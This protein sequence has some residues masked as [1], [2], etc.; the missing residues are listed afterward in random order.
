MANTKLRNEPKRAKRTQNEPKQLPT[1]QNEP[2]GALKWPKTTQKKQKRGKRRTKMSQN[3]GLYQIT[4][5]P[6]TS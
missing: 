4:Q 3:Y 1:T 2:K 5:R 6:K